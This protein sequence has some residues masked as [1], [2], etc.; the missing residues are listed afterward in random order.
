MQTSLAGG[1]PSLYVLSSSAVY[2]DILYFALLTA[3]ILFTIGWHTR[4]I[5]VIFFVLL[6][7]LHARNPLATNGGDNLARIILVYLVFAQ[8]GAHWS[9]D[10]LRARRRLASGRPR[11]RERVIGTVAHNAALIA[12]VAQVCV[13]YATSSLFKVQGE[14]W[15]NGTALYYI[16]RTADYNSWPEVTVFV[17]QWPIVVVGATYAAV[18]VQLCLPF[19][20]VNRW[21]KAVLLP[22]VL[23]MHVAI[24]IL[25]G[26]PFFSLYMVVTD[27]FFLTDRDL[28][29]AKVYMTGYLARFGVSRPGRIARLVAPELVTDK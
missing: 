13:L 21:V 11:R 9:L 27:L 12:C 25:M 22:L 20:L 18:F 6:W 2:A 23:G 14:M 28:R 24:G 8:V 29:L 19:A 1:Q 16:L 15:Q 3:A 5:T 26:L 7:S 10:S 17:Y 4:T